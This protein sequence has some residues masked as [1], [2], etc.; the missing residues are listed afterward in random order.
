LTASTAHGVL[1]APPQRHGPFADRTEAGRELAAL[2]ASA[3]IADPI[4]LAIPRGGAP[5]AEEIARR[6][7]ADRDLLIARKVG[8]PRNPEFGVGAVAEG[9]IRYLD[10]T[11]IREA[12]L[13]EADLEARVRA[14]EQEVARRAAT[15]R[16]GRGRTPLKGRNAILVDDGVATGGT[17][18]AAI[19]SARTA[20]TSS[21]T[22]AL[23]VCPASTASRLRRLADRVA[24]ALL[25]EWF[26]AVG[27]WY[28]SFGPVAD[29]DVVR[30]L[31]G[32]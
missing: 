25:P 3:G 30:Y 1:L 7:A 31:R 4:V 32:S 23:G 12:G 17:M 6:L 29:E 9:G 2:L 11:N 20:G 24:V 22:A 19:E 14:E 8:A 15:Y 27:Q 16:K 18:V 21:V 28:R 26:D 13:T 10:R 5:V